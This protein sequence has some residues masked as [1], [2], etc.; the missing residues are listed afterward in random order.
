[1]Q[2]EQRISAVALA[3]AVITALLAGAL[4]SLAIRPPGATV[5][6]AATASADAGFSTVR[7]RVTSSF[8][9][10]MPVI[11]G[12]P[13]KLA[14]DLREISGGTIDLEYFEPGEVVPAF[15]ITEAVKDRKIDAGFMWVGYD[16]GRIP[17][18]TLISA[19]P[20][21]MEP[22]EFTAWWYHGGGQALGEA[23][24]HEHN[25]QPVLCNIVGPETAG[26]F[27]EPIRSLDDLKGL[28]IRFAGIGG[29][30][31]QRLGASVTMIPGGE[32][33]QALE[34]GAIDASEF[35]LPVVDR[36]L[37][38]GRVA[39]YNYFPGWHQTFATGH[40]MINLDA[41]NE[42]TPATRKLIDTA[43]M[44]SVTWVFSEGEATQGAVIRDFADEGISAE[45]LPLEL[46]EELRRVATEVLDEE[47]ANDE[48]FARILE[49]QR[50][51]SAVYAYWKR[52]GY[53]PRDF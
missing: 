24:Y 19:V 36:M 6:S 21:G 27:R 17:A 41:W 9:S 53:L 40:M 39:P 26:W 31:L 25:V 46:L 2:E 23:L 33:F 51:F 45:T 3:I 32:I 29:K 30:I 38:F 1:M 50:Q 5:T 43:C 42:L 4:L 35:S 20:F 22:M 14:E 13:V 10:V 18:S 37:G 8:T 12:T 28:K 48:H 15:E 49:S 11:G 44:A 34:K 7:W 52:K 47:A 16:Q